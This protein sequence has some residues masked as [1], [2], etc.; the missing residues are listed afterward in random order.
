MRVRDARGPR[1]LYAARV[2]SVVLV[3]QQGGHGTGSI[4]AP[5][6][7]L[8]ND[9]VVRGSDRVSIALYLEN[10]NRDRGEIDHW[11]PARVLAHDSVLDLA[12]LEAE[13]PADLVPIALAD[14][15][16]VEVGSPAYAIGHPFPGGGLWSLTQGRIGARRRDFGGIGRDVFQTD[17]AINPGNSG[18]PLLDDRGAM[19]GVNVSKVVKEGFEG[20]GFA[21]QSNTACR[22]MRK[23]GVHDLD[24]PVASD[25][26]RLPSRP[27]RASLPKFRADA[28]ATDGLLTAPRP[29]DREA[30][31]RSVREEHDEAFGDFARGQDEAFD[32]F[33]R[34]HDEAFGEFDR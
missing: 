21:I 19:I 28:R 20:L 4:V 11:H 6:R 24:C 30:I 34:E 16:R 14:S 32:D 3:A 23:H 15:G 5:G 1:D 17:A 31:F 29:L 27:P 33:A 18:G 9:H 2:S 26:V 22:W 8:T 7:V 13:L 25:A 10:P 12:L